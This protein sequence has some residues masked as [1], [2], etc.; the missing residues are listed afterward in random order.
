MNRKEIESMFTMFEDF[1]SDWEQRP[2]SVDA[3]L[4]I[5]PDKLTWA[6][7][8]AFVLKHFKKSDKHPRA[9]DISQAWNEYWVTALQKG[10]LRKVCSDPNHDRQWDAQT[11]T[12]K[13]IGVWHSVEDENGNV[14]AHKCPYVLPFVQDRA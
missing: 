6:F 7:A 10:D 12:D 4:N 3:W 1:A 11:Q 13:P 9:H 8:H 14:K 2:R 5:L